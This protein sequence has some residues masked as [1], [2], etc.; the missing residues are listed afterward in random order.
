M[1]QQIKILNQLIEKHGKS[2]VSF[3]LYINECP[4]DLCRWTKPGKNHIKVNPRAAITINR[5]FGV[6]AEL[7]RPDLFKGV[8]LV[9]KDKKDKKQ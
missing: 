4:S 8:K 1:D 6:D 7:L 5:L 3:A 2:K 9:F